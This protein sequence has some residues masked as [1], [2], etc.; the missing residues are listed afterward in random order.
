MTVKQIIDLDY[1]VDENA[2]ILQKAL[3][4]IQPLSK[5]E[6]EEVPL[7]AI[8]KVLHSMSHKYDLWVSELVQDPWSNAKFDIWR[9]VIF[10]GKS[11]LK[12]V[13]GA[14]IYEVL[15]KMVILM[16]SKVKSGKAGVR[17]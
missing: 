16:Y 6:F 8:E 17:K 12:P 15:A 2:N 1:R 9:G 4:Q 14:S 5:Y 7:W 3:R 11:R 13:F 10:M